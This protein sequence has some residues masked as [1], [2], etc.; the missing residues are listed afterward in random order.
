MGLVRRLFTLDPDNDVTRVRLFVQPISERWA[1][2]VL[3]D[4]RVRVPI[5]A[6]PGT[7]R[8]DTQ[9]NAGAPR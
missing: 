5:S 9:R 2:M 1:A 6:H 8:R 3:G 7:V 4:T